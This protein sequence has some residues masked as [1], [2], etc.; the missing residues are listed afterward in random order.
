MRLVQAD[1]HN[2]VCLKVVKTEIPMARSL[3]YLNGFGAVVISCH[4]A[5]VLQVVDI[6]ERIKMKLSRLKDQASLVTELERRRESCD[7]T[8][9]DLKQRLETCLLAEQ[10]IYESQGKKVDFVHLDRDI[11]P[12]SICV[13]SDH[14]LLFL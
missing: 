5:Q 10:R 6:E 9:K 12:S 2:P 3:S 13:L 4:E 8:V 14:L 1:L 7:G 11:K